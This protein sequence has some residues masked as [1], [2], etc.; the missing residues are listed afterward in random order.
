MVIQIEDLYSGQKRQ[1]SG[2]EQQVE[3]QIR[4]EYPDFCHS[5]AYG[6]LHTILKEII[7]SCGFSVK[8]LEGEVQRKPWLNPLMRHRP[9][10]DPW[11]RE[12][13]SPGLE[14]DTELPDKKEE[15]D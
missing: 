15:F 13:D 9:K 11:T 10:S 5:A 3:D 2:N 8:V 4:D 7:R 12:V 1:F 6:D 14:V